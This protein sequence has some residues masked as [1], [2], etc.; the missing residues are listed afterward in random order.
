MLESWLATVVLSGGSLHPQILRGWTGAIT[1]SGSGEIWGRHL[2]APVRAFHQCLRVLSITNVIS[3]LSKD[4]CASWLNFGC[5]AGELECC[6]RSSHHGHNLHRAFQSLLSASSACLTVANHK[7]W[8]DHKKGRNNYMCQSHSAD[9]T[10]LATFY[11]AVP[12]TVHA[13]R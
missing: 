10:F 13:A 8:V 5:D 4:V 12:A 1:S 3:T 9:R 6:V 7:Q 11:P 2:G